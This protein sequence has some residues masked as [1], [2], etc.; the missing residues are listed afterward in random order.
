MTWDLGPLAPAA[1]RRITLYDRLLDTYYALHPAD[2]HYARWQ[3]SQPMANWLADQVGVGRGPVHG[4]WLFGVPC[5]LANDP[6]GLR[7]KVTP[8][9]RWPGY[10]DGLPPDGPPY[11][12]DE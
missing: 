4:A 1:R 8:P 11:A 5:D 6:G 12:E 2:R 9:R 7:L 3:L 10:L